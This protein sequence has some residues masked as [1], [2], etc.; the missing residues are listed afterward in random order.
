MVTSLKAAREYS[1][2][3]LSDDTIDY[4]TFALLYNLNKSDNLDL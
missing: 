2:F 4:E 1:L 3:C